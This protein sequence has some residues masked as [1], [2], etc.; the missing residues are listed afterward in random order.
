MSLIHHDEIARR[1]ALLTQWH[2]R[3]NALEKRY[4]RGSFDGA[5]HFVNRVASLA[6]AHDHH[7]DIAVSWKVVTITLTS[8]DLG[9]ITERDFRLASAIDEMAAAST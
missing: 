3:G 5:I 1:V 6:N 2:H 4:D 8:H 7:P 9:G